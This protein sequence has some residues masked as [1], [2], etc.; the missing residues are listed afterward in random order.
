ML[1]EH[2]SLGDLN[3]NQR[4]DPLQLPKKKQINFPFNLPS[5]VLNAFTVKAFNFLFYSKNFKKGNQ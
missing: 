5:W 1:G 2:A 4:R 3:D